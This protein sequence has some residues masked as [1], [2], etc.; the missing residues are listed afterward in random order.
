MKVA[1]PWA[2][3]FQFHYVIY[4]GKMQLLQQLIQEFKRK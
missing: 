4:N 2:K 3:I 1:V